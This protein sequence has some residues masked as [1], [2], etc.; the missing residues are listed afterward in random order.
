MGVVTQ[1]LKLPPLRLL[2]DTF[3]NRQCQAFD[4]K[5]KGV[6]FTFYRKKK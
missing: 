5:K 2:Y 3:L 1:I 4:P 6:F